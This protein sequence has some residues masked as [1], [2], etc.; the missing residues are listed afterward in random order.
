MLGKFKRHADDPDKYALYVAHRMKP[1]DNNNLLC[2]GAPGSG[3]SRGFIIPFLLGVAARKESVFISDPK[4]ELFEKLSPYFAEQ[5]YYVKAVNFL[6]MEHSDGWNCLYNLENERQLV[7]TVANTII[8]NTS[9]PREANDF[10]SRAELNLLMAMLH[11][12]CNLK[13]ENG[14]LLPIEERGLGTIYNILATETVAQINARFEEL[15]PN[16]PAKGP[17]GLFVKTK[18]NLWGSI[19]TGLGNRLAVFQNQLVDKVTRNHDVDLLLPG[20]KPCAYFVIISAQDSAYRFLSSLF[21]SLAIPM[22]SDY[23]RLQCPGGRLPVLVNFCL[24]EYLNIGHME[25]SDALNS[26]RG[27]NMAC[28]V[29][30]QSLSQWQEKY[31]GKEWENQLATFNQTLYM[32]CNDLTSAKYI[33]EKCGKVTISVTNNQMP[34]MPLFSPVYTSTRPYSQTRSNTQRDL[35]Q[36]DEILRLEYDKCIAL[37]QGHKPALLYKLTPEEIPGYGDLRSCRVIDYTPEWK[38]KEAETPACTETTPEKDKSEAEAKSEQSEELGMCEYTANQV[39][40]GDDDL[41]PPRL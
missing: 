10:W 34:L 36:P 20:Q 2:I 6:D 4:G 12:V 7:Q 24:D 33:S 32:G 21:F 1:G 16:H 11:Y 29:V 19:I 18:D 35:M 30:V 5:G 27:F 37:F 25:I 26:I 28:Q 17:H 22:L 31:P 9:G 13:D 8:L 23:A 38:R 3:K 40:N 41:L 14:R 39:V 15:A